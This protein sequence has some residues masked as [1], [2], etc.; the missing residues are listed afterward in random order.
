MHSRS[1]VSAADLSRSEAEQLLESALALKRQPRGS[2]P[3]E[4]RVLAMLFEKPSLRT[5]VSFETG[6]VQLGGHA[7]YLAPDD[8]RAGT[9]ESL[10][11]VARNLSRLADGIMART[12]AHAT[13]QTL[14]DHAEVPVINGLSD[15]E[16]PCQALADFL[17]LHE[18]RDLARRPTLA[19]VGDGTNVCHS[20]MLLSRVLDV[21]LR[22]ACPAGYEPAPEFQTSCP[23]VLVTPDPVQAVAGAD[24]VYTDVWASMGQEDQAEA[25]RRIFRPYQVNAALMAG[26]A[27]DAIFLHCLPAHRGEEVTDEVLD[28]PQSAAYDQAENRLHAQKALLVMLIA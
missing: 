17:T 6:M 22:V 11:D 14:A 10:P 28:G 2:R 5:R 3:L 27:K 16:H 7:I 24:A 9:R 1:F 19:Y 15:R 21:P 23:A 12:F 8:V 25:R 13:V 4:R 20:L 26:A 18:H